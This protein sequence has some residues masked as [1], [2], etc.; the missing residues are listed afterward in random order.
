M[1][2]LIYYP[3]FEVRNPDWLKFALLYLDKLD[4]IIPHSGNAYLTAQYRKLMDE[5]DLISSHRPSSS[6]GATATLDALD[7]I[8]KI[9]KYPARYKS[10]FQ[11]LNIVEVWKRPENQTWTLF[12]EKYTAT[13]KSFCIEN[14]LGRQSDERRTE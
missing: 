7:H 11:N 1:Q 9:L 2:E 5:A 4:P 6:E 12:E 3:G 10:I 8:E 13:W 14:N